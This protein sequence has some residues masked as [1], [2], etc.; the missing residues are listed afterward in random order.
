[1][2]GIS[3]TRRTSA[4]VAVGLLVVVAAALVLFVDFDNFIDLRVYRA[5]GRAW[6]DG[7]TLYSNEFVRR[8]GVGLPFTYP[9]VSAML[10]TTV[11]VIPFGVAIALVTVASLAALAGTAAIVVRRPRLAILA[12]VAGGLLLEPVRQTLSFGQINLLLMVLVVAD[13]L[14]PRTWWPRGLL[15]GIAA[16]VK[17]T[18][19][20]FVL[21]FLARGQ[22]RPVLAAL[23]GFA[24][25]TAVAWVASPGAISAYLSTVIEDPGRI[26]GLTYAGNQSLNGFWHRL[27]L[28]DTATKVLWLGSAAVVVALGW[29]AVRASREAGDDL[30]ALVAAAAVGLLVSPVSWSHHW[31]WVA[32]AAIWV[33]RRLREWHLPAQLAAVAGLLLFVTPPHWLLPRQHNRE[34]HWALWQHVLGND[35]VWCALA[36]LVVL[37]ATGFR[38]GPPGPGPRRAA[39]GQQPGAEPPPET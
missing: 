22:W 13:C 25:A 34:R 8:S 7:Y 2:A 20:V 24:A 23:A 9:P 30:G 28:G 19:A 35:Y 26:G 17:L 18:P 31:V 1:M 38:R 33:V 5:G 12:A 10:F 4:V 15:I 14:L 39:A 36:L 32:V 29:R 21:F 11:A 3:M 37:A 16:A 6:L 27:D